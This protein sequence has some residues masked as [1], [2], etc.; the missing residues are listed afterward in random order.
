[1]KRLLEGQGRGCRNLLLLLAWF[2]GCTSMYGTALLGLESR[3]EM[4]ARGMRFL[5]NNFFSE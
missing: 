3:D 2:L 4:L 1:V 5:V